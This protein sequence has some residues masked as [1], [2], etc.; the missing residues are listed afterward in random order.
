M[1][2]LVAFAA[3]PA[4]AEDRPASSPTGPEDQPPPGVG[5][6]QPSAPT[7][8]EPGSAPEPAL[9]ADEEFAQM[10]TDHDG[11]VSAQEFA[12]SPRSW[13]DQAA[14]GKRRGAAGLTGGFDLRANENRPD[15]SPVFR[16]RDRNHDGYLSRDELSN[17]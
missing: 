1:A 8:L 4:F 2:G 15:R 12:S 11:R 5:R 16:A 17:R 13:V 6:K 10:D 7:L 9:T 14:N 3:G